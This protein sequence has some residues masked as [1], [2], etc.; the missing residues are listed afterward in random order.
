MVTIGRPLPGKVMTGTL[1]ETRLHARQETT[2][3][4]I[5]RLKTIHLLHVAALG[6]AG[7]DDNLS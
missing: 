2:R 3:T 6:V 5:I 4:K 7:L 1:C